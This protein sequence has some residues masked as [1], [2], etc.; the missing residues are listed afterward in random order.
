MANISGIGALYIYANEPAELAAWY[1]AKLGFA[2]EHNQQENSHFGQLHDPSTN[3]TVYLAVCPAKAELP[4]GN[5]GTMINY[6][7]T[8]YDIFIGKLER[9]GV[10]IESRRGDGPSKFA[11]ISDPEGNQIELWSGV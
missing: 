8:D 2:F 7:V 5:R 4:Y 11:I 6:K 9:A 1:Q 10:R 3:I